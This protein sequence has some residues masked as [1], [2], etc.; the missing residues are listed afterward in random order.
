MFVIALCPVAEGV[1]IN[2]LVCARRCGGE[3]KRTFVLLRSG[4]V[5]GAALSGEYSAL[6]RACCR[7]V[8][9]W[10]WG[11]DGEGMF[12]S[13]LVGGMSR[14]KTNVSGCS[15]LPQIEN[16]C[17]S[18]TLWRKGTNVCD[19]ALSCGGGRENECSGLRPAL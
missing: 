17:F 3:K 16:K 15:P 14:G 11:R 8:W 12:G 4:T 5:T 1:K 19:Y 10:Q 18:L 6:F 9:R 13:L 2:V 7:G